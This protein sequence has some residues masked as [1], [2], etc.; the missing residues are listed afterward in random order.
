MTLYLRDITD[1]RGGAVI[2]PPG[3]KQGTRTNQFLDT[4]LRLLINAEKNKL[5]SCIVLDGDL[6]GLKTSGH[7]HLHA[8][9]LPT[10]IS[11]ILVRITNTITPPMI[12]H[13]RAP[14]FSQPGTQYAAWPHLRALPHICLGDLWIP[15]PT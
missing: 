13:C 12:T 11:L 5:L 9:T 6:D 14:N 7:N 10:P 3:W 4:S 8:N 2:L 15:E 1:E